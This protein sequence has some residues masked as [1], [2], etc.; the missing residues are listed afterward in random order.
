MKWN[1]VPIWYKGGVMGLIVFLLI[2]I[3]PFYHYLVGS[4]PFIIFPI[5]M[6]FFFIGGSILAIL[7]HKEL[8][9]NWLKGGLISLFIFIFII[10]NHHYIF[11]SLSEIVNVLS[12]T[13]EIITGGWMSY[14][15]DSYWSKINFKGIFFSAIIFFISGSLI[16]FLFKKN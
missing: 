2:S 5:Q 9:Y 14:D 10:S 7:I 1:N 4:Y 12:Q 16:G 13:F 11:R 15:P 6:L 8:P 3:I